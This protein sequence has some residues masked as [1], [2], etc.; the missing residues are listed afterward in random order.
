MKNIKLSLAIVAMALLTIISSCSKTETTTTNPTTCTSGAMTGTVNGTS[1]TASTYNNTLLRATSNGVDAKR[2]DIRATSSTG[3]SLILSLSDWRDGI[4]GEGFHLGTY[5][6]AATLNPCNANNSACS[7]VLITYQ[8]VISFPTGGTS[9]GSVII[10]S[11]DAVNHKI[12]GTFTA[13]ARTGGSS[14]TV[15]TNG[16]FTDVCYTVL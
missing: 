9:A 2:L 11:C 5:Y 6:V 8:N 16:V 7:G 1:F 14:N 4:V 13:N 15:I 3:E 10:T 12:S